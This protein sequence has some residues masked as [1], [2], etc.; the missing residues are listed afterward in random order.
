MIVGIYIEISMTYYNTYC[1]HNRNSIS[2]YVLIVI[3]E[4]YS[5]FWSF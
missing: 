1:S 4:Y 3:A 5:N 2:I